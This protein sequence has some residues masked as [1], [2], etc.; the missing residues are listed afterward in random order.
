MLS[1]TN[2]EIECFDKSI[3]SIIDSFVHQIIKLTSLQVS[4]FIFALF[5]FRFYS[6][7]SLLIEIWN[8]NCEIQSGNASKTDFHN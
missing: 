3:V 1:K 4:H 8:F 6:L 2:T 7:I 5:Y